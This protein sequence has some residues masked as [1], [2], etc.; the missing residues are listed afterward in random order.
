MV[1]AL[2]W[3]VPHAGRGAA[4]AVARVALPACA[5]KRGQHS[6]GDDDGCATPGEE[7]DLGSHRE[8]LL[9]LE[10]E[11]LERFGRLAV[12]A[13]RTALITATRREVA[14]GNPGGRAMRCG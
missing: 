8:H 2:Q 5:G 3:A 12:Q 7:S 11:V 4:V 10:P 14:L 1:M 9:S 13:R 6:Q